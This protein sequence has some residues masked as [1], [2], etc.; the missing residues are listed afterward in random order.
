MNHKEKNTVPGEL[1]VSNISSLLEDFKKSFIT[2]EATAG[3]TP[4]LFEDERSKA[5]YIIVHLAAN[6]IAKISDL[7]AVLTPEDGEEYKLNRDIYTDN[8]A[9]QVMKEDACKG[10]RFEDIVVEFDPSYR[11]DKPLK[12]FG[13]QHR[14]TAITEAIKSGQNQ[15]HGLRIYFG[16]NEEQRLDVAKANNTAI[17][18]ANDLLDRMQEDYLGNE[19]RT[20]CQGVGFL[21]AAQNFADKRSAIGIPTVRIARTFITNFQLAKGRKIEELQEPIVCQSGPQLDSNY[22]T[23]RKNVVWSNPEM[24]EAGK[25]FV[26]LHK[27]QR[28]RVSGRSKDSYSEYANKALHPCIVAGWAYAAGLFQGHPAEL[29]KHFNIPLSV[30]NQKDQD[31]LGAADL[32]KARLKGVDPDTYRGLGA[33]IGAGEL[34]RMLEVFVLH[35]TKA[36]KL[37][38]NLKLANAAIQN[39]EAKK[40]TQAANKTIKGI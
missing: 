12:V 32:S 28:E 17:A 6:T 39:Y 21:D 31:P 40:Q 9:Y 23:V 25:Q 30:S 5:H 15:S 37:G 1:A 7:E 24:L 14:V 26:K 11:Q 22:E 33:R 4:I 2:V 19:L 10:R 34:G 8:Y 36:T 38:I 18:V 29:A 13:G 35:A 16:L 20:W 3:L 27:L